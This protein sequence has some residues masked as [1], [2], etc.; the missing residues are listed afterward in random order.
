MYGYRPIAQPPI[1][2]SYTEYK[3]DVIPMRA[4]FESEPVDCKFLESLDPE[5]AEG[6]IDQPAPSGALD[7]QLPGGTFPM[8]GAPA[9][10]PVYPTPPMPPT[11]S[12][13]PLKTSAL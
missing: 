12:Q 8:P 13:P 2:G 7:Q 3:K 5:Q 1:L 4:Q 6:V 9:S 11:F 10:G